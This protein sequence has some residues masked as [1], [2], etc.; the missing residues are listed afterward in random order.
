MAGYEPVK[1][2]AILIPTG[3]TDHL[4]IICCD[5]IFYPVIN[6][7]CILLVN[8][9]SVDEDMYYDNTCILNIGDHPFIKHPSYVFYKKAVIYGV[10]SICRNVDEGNFFIHHPTNEAV[11]QRIIA[12]FEASSEVRG[13]IKRFY[14]KYCK[15]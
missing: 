8:I 4:H 6:K 11:Y 12:G 5:P 1:K 13:K 3:P 2:G 14:D 15:D 10:E 9:S 7:D